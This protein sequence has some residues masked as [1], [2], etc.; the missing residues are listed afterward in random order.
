MVFNKSLVKSRLEGILIIVILI[1]Y[2]ETI[3]I[4]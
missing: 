4:R 1:I 2:N 3:S